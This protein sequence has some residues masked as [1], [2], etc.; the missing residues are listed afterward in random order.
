[1]SVRLLSERCRELC[2]EVL[3]EKRVT[4]RKFAELIWKLVATEPGIEY[5]PLHYKPLEKVKEKELKIHKGNF[6]SFMIISNQIL[7]SI[8]WWINNM[9]S[10]Y[11][12]ISHA[13]TSN[14][15]KMLKIEHEKEFS[16]SIKGHNSVLI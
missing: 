14:G 13:P 9:K 10:S 1:M 4:I 12:L 8:E 6:D 16:T 11:K 7:P 2:Q 3:S 5:A 15:S